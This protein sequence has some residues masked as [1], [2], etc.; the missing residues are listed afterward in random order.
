M[1]T[2]CNKSFSALS[3]FSYWLQKFRFVQF[4]LLFCD[5]LRKYNI[6][7]RFYDKGNYYQYLMTLSRS[8]CVFSLIIYTHLPLTK[9]WQSKIKS[10]H[11]MEMAYQPNK[12]LRI[13]SELKIKMKRD[14][15]FGISSLKAT[16]FD[17]SCSIR[18]LKC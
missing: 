11:L 1:N 8:S 2:L 5:L 12:P 14:A 13:Y 6:T 18:L 16:S 9:L 10:P 7:R 17:L 15:L 4:C 3:T